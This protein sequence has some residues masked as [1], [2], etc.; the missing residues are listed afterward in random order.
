MRAVNP[1]MTPADAPRTTVTA[2]FRW[3]ERDADWRPRYNRV[4]PADRERLLALG[5][6]RRRRQAANAAAATAGKDS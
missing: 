4:D 2:P 6:A 1:A 3:T 5:E